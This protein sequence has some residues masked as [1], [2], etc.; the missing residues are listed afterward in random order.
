MRSSASTEPGRGFRRELLQ[1]GVAVVTVGDDIVVKR[2]AQSD[3]FSISHNGIRLV[4]SQRGFQAHRVRESGESPS[5]GR[6]GWILK[7]D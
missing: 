5:R 1:Q 6:K 7:G 3:K 2:C 4:G